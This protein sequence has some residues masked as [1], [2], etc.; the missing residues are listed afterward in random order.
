MINLPE[1]S[2]KRIVIIGG[3]FAGLSLARK[4]AKSDYQVVL[5]DKN[6][7][8]QFQPLFYQVAMSGLEPSSIVF[9][10]RKLFHNRQNVY[11]RVTEVLS[12]EWEKNKLNTPLGIV[13]F[14]YLI[15]AT[16]A[17]TNYF[18]NKALEKLTIPMKS[19]SEA[20]YLRNRILADYETAHSITDYAERQ[21]YLDI[22]IVGG[23]ATGVE[24]AGAIAEMRN[25]IFH[26]D[27]PELNPGEIDIYLIHGADQL[28]K[29]MSEA[30][31]GKAFKFLE[32]LGVNI[33]LN[34]RVTDFDGTTITMSDG[35]TLQAY[36]VVWAAGIIAN[37][38]K[39]LPD[40]CFTYGGR[41]KVDRF[42]LVEGTKNIFAVG[43]VAFMEEENYPHG[44]PQVAQVALQQ[45]HNLANNFKRK[46]KAETLRPFSYDDKGSMA[47]IGKHKA[48]VDL[49]K[50]KF[51]GFFAWIVWLVVHLF[52]LIGVKNRIFVFLNWVW[53]YLTYD[54]SL[55][56]LIRPY[57]PGNKNVEM[58]SENEPEKSE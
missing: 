18:G 55:R 54:Q 36:K 58:V 30:A 19:V 53:N 42:H 38:I 10:L 34:T 16:G 24:V 8:H 12:I 17:R 39:G 14:D 31:S 52:Q 48:V 46:Q 44:H 33:K 29:G 11:I 51:Q 3:G 37:G 25:T 26:K 47:T 49:P 22:I 32:A 21:K 27:Y 9:P 1:S 13:N 23:G 15:I 45:A 56:L 28:L 35:S 2:Q 40:S 6:N 20:L 41:L 4:L 57:N 5:L 43:D 50:W 7:Y